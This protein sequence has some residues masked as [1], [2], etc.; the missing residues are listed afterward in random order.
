MWVQQSHPWLPYRPVGSASHTLSEM[1][2]CSCRCSC[3]LR[4]QSIPFSSVLCTKL[5]SF[6]G[7]HWQVGY[8]SF[9]KWLSLSM[10]YT[11]GNREKIVFVSRTRIKDTHCIHKGVWGLLHHPGSASM[12]RWVKCGCCYLTVGDFSAELFCSVSRIVIHE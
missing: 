4:G 7:Q 6:L 12:Q 8:M 2:N 3:G 1:S 11:Q 9:D 5:V 10:A